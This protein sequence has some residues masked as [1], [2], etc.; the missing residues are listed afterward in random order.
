MGLGG[1]GANQSVAARVLGCEVAL[2]AKV[3]SDSFGKNF[4]SRLDALGIASH[5]VTESTGAS[6]GVAFVI[7]E[8]DRGQNRIIVIPGANKHLTPGDIDSAVTRNLLDCHVLVCQFEINVLTTLH[9]LRLARKHG[10]VTILNPAPPLKHSSELQPSGDG[11]L[12]RELLSTCDYCCPNE[13]EAA[14]LVDH[15]PSVDFSLDSKENNAHVIPPVFIE[16][17]NWMREQ[18]VKYPVITLGSMGALALI[19]NDTMHESQSDVVVVQCTGSGTVVQV[20]APLITNVVDTTGAGDCFIGALSFFIARYP[21]L[22]V[23]ERLRRAVWVA[24]QSVRREGTQSSYPN[25]NEL[26]SEL[27]ETSTFTWP[28]VPI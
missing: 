12:I 2:V 8:C 28:N 17:L 4:V 25:R 21:Q 10:A 27:F 15:V 9:S 13:T 20:R 22:S 19:S 14:H 7:V 26:P 6:T 23:I 3:G 5:G 16:C 24:S 1:K 18:G 11:D